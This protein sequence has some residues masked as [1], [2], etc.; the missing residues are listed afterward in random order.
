MY[1]TGDLNIYYNCKVSN[2]ITEIEELHNLNQIVRF[3]TRVTPTNSTSIDVFLTTNPELHV[4]TE[5]LKI[6]LSDHYMVY[7][8]IDFKTKSK[9]VNH[10][11]AT[12]R[13]YKKFNES[14]F[15]NEIKKSFLQIELDHCNV[16]ESWH[17]WKDKFLHICD[18]Y[19][20][21]RRM[22]VKNRNN[23]WIDNEVLDKMYER[24]HIHKKAVSCKD[25]ELWNQY[26]L[27][28][29]EV[30]SLIR[31]KK[32]EYYVDKLESSKT[33]KEM[34]NIMNSIVPNKKNGNTIPPEMDANKFNKYFSE[35]G[36]TL[37]NKH[38]YQF[39]MEKSRLY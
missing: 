17:K 28:R 14:C 21:I 5:L 33:S 23:P 16:N 7:T 36:L 4:K 39:T 15:I 22:R 31:N 24:D 30:T 26:K 11:Y 1:I 18:K 37:A 34:W 3:S 25:D 10:K 27:L 13:S 2:L 29:N 32:K 8:I 9:K 6:G 20:P 35:I 19:A 12:F 38:R